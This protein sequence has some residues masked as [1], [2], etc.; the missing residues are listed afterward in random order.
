MFEVCF[1]YHNKN[2]LKYHSPKYLSSEIDL[3]DIVVV[4]EAGVHLEAMSAGLSAQC[5]NEEDLTTFRTYIS[6]L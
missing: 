5:R 6:T 1:K 3:N 4:Y 2:I